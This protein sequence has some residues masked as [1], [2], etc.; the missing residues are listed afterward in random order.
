MKT[1]TQK[2]KSKIRDLIVKS[3]SEGKHETA[4]QLYQ[5]YFLFK[6]SLWKKNQQESINEWSRRVFGYT[7]NGYLYVNN[8]KV[9]K[10]KRNPNGDHIEDDDF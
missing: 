8:K 6:K 7:K 2:F 10:L 4:M 9:K 5:T 3:T 1:P